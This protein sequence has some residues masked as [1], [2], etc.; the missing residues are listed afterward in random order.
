MVIMTETVGPSSP[1]EDPRIT[2]EA[3]MAAGKAVSLDWQNFVPGMRAALEAAVP[4]LDPRPLLDRE[5]VY[6][7]ISGEAFIGPAEDATAAVMALARSVPTREQI[8]ALLHDK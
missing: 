5:A 2:N 7:A 6:R 1:R 3:V 8:G 4:L